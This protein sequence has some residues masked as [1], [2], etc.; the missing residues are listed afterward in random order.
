M[1]N[2]ATIIDH[3]ES[4]A[5]KLLIEIDMAINVFEEALNH[6]QTEPGLNGKAY[7]T[8]ETK[9]PKPTYEILDLH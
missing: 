2:R 1:K 9:Y 5:T 6:T 8:Y 4:E 7:P 3:N